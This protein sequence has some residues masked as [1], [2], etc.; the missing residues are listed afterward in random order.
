MTIEVRDAPEE[1]RFEIVVDGR[2]AG[3][4]EYRREDDHHYTFFHTEIDEAFAGQGLAS[5]LIGGALD[6]MRARGVTVEP[7]CSFVRGFIEKHPDY[8]DLRGSS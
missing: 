6:E 7:T 3:F 1:R 8:S 4:T 5:K 2:L